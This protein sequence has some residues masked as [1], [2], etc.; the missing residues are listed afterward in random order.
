MHVISVRINICM[1]YT[2]MYKYGSKSNWDHCY[3][4]ILRDKVT[5]HMFDCNFDS[6]VCIFRRHAY[7]I[8]TE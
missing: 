8:Y 6:P 5:L 7:A 2:Y 1:N 4:S 3:Y